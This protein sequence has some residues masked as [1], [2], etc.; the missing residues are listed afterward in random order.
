MVRMTGW[1]LGKPAKQRHSKNALFVHH[2]PMDLRAKLVGKTVVIPFGGDSKAITF[3]AVQRNVRFSLKAHQPSE[4]RKRQAEAQ[5]HLERYF[6][7]VRAGTDVKLSMRQVATLVGEQHQSWATDYDAV[8]PVRVDARERTILDPIPASHEDLELEAELLETIGRDLAS[9]DFTFTVPEGGQ[10]I[11]L[12]ALKQLSQKGIAAVSEDSL[13]ATA[14]R[15]PAAIGTGLEV[16]ARKLKGDYSPDP[17]ATRIP[18][19]TDS[20]K[21]QATPP[22][23]SG[24]VSLTALV[25]S[26]WNEAKAAGLSESTYVSYSGS[27]RLLSAFLGHDDALRVT[28]E[29]IIAFKDHRLKAINPKTGKPASAK[30]IKASDLTAFK[31]VFEW[32]KVNL[33]VPSNPATGITVK[34]GKKVKVREREFTAEEASLILAAA[35][36]FAIKSKPTQ[37]HSMKRWVPWLCAYSGCRVGELIQ[38][39]KEDV[40]QDP[41]TGAW[42]LKITPEAGTVKGKERRDIPVHGHLIEMG[43]LEFAEKAPGGYLF[44]NVKPGGSFR[45]VLQSKKNRMTEFVREL[46][47]D[48]NVAPNHGWRHT[49]KAKGFEVG[50]QEKV[51]DF[52]CGHAP[53]TVGRTYGSVTMPTRVDAMKVF[54]RYRLGERGNG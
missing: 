20:P 24:A 3:N 25:D 27:F 1:G 52:I 12:S 34:L 15:L 35:N 39:R 17:L 19:W 6:E 53:A 32:A 51:L 22:K 49:F 33:K 47:P 2:I 40:G 28:P 14:S 21:P 43:F 11:E 42:V 23:R 9:G 7:E 8:P 13:K 4:V 41:E 10:P 50:I 29:D 36:S 38:L 46:V 54:P 37:T 16:A 18:E 5:G 44:L 26:W 45:G 30:T 48:P 31:S